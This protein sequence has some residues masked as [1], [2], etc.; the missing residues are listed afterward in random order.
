MAFIFHLDLSM[1][2]TLMYLHEDSGVFRIQ[3]RERHSGGGGV[4]EKKGGG[5][6]KER[7]RGGD[8]EDYYRV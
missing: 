2:L 1:I 5:E 4:G 8:F 6:G 7:G 3:S